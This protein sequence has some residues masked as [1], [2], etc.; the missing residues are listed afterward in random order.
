MFWTR[1]SPNHEDS[2]D[3][4]RFVLNFIETMMV[5]LFVL[6]SEGK[7]IVWNKACESLTG[8][9]TQDVIGT[10]EH[11][12]GFYT[13]ARPCLADLVLLGGG[14]KVNSLYNAVASASAQTGQMQASNWCSLPRGARRY[15]T[16][17]AV[18]IFNTQGKIIA[19]I[20]TIQDM[21]AL[22]EAEQAVLAQRETQTQNLERIKTCLG[23]GLD[24][25]AQ[26]DLE[27]RVDTPLPDMADQLR[28]NFNLAAHG[29]QDLLLNI[30]QTAET[31]D[32]GTTELAGSVQ[33]LARHSQRQASDISRTT[34][35]LGTIS[36][37]MQDT[38]SHVTHVRDIVA[39][40]KE[41][42]EQSAAIVDKTITTIND[43][44]KSSK[45]ISQIVGLIDEIAFQTNLLALNAG[46]EAARAGEA[47][48]GFAV[49]AAEV[50]ALAVRSAE[51]AGE[52]KGLITK[53][54]QQVDMGVDLVT[55]TGTALARI[56]QEVTQI[57]GAVANITASSQQQAEGLAQISHT[58]Q[59]IDQVA[60]NTMTIVQQ[61][62]Q[63]TQNLQLMTAN[64][65]EMI[66]KFNIG[67]V[68]GQEN[69]RLTPPYAAARRLSAVR[70][71]H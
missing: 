28:Q 65:H 34:L 41:D 33:S 25:L 2:L 17:D 26:G 11:W 13:A 42:A 22:K 21:T 55:R 57:N 5:P 43:I 64:M 44:E 51:A 7:V 15:L 27:V 4:F 8:L 56:M 69:G 35:S 16:L 68:S 62:I 50:R 67:A 9:R 70:A 19:V 40:A 12:R 59:D 45:Q 29:L 30:H 47:G 71:Q 60:L 54:S 3:N 46:V 6:N 63:A 39:K 18:A 32:E 58:M 66:G 49:V 52:I 31:I 36:T 14:G 48:R 23:A 10:N 20:E 24:Q 53:S 37:T 38:V 1:K 61:S